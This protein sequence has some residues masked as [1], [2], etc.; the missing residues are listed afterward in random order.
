[1][2]RATIIAAS[3][4]VL[5]LTSACY[6]TPLP[7]CSFQCSAAGECPSGYSCSAVD[8]ICK[9]DDVAADFECPGLIIADAAAPAFDASMSDAAVTDASFIDAATPDAA[10]P[11]GMVPDAMV[12]DAMVPDAMVPDAMA[13]CGNGTQEPSESCDDNNDNNCGS[14]NMGCG[15]VQS[16]TAA[17]GSITAIDP[18]N[19]NDTETFTINDGLGTSVTFEF[20]KTGGTTDVIVDI[21]GA[22]SAAD[23][24]TAI[25]AA[26]TG[27]AGL[28][29]SPSD[30]G[31]AIVTLTHDRLSSL[32]NQT[33]TDTVVDAGFVVSGLSGGVAGDCT[34]GIGCS[35]ND[36]CASGTCNAGTC[37]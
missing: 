24:K 31:G 4:S 21:S 5:A 17:T 7:D 10:T 25:I 6:E 23:V 16:P 28:Q 35:G 3:V 20:E 2:L 33:V 26:I 34:T 18:A 30:G 11:D 14:C 32:G 15:T 8:N 19:I 12:P 9:R 29:V 13:V 36:D 37:N 27:Q 22:A 1:M